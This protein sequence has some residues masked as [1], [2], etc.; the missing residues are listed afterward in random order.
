MSAPLTEDELAVLDALERAAT[1]VGSAWKKDVGCY[2]DPDGD[3]DMW[4]ARG[5]ML[6]GHRAT[7][8]PKAESDA[9]FIAALRN[10]APKLIAMA[11]DSLT[12]NHDHVVENEQHEAIYLRL[13]AERDHLAAE[14]ER[15][16]AEIAD[17]DAIHVYQL[18][19]RDRLAADVERLRAEIADADAIHVYQLA[20]RDRLAADVERLRAEL[21]QQRQG[22]LHNIK[23]ASKIQRELHDTINDERREATRLRAALEN[24]R[25][26]CLTICEANSIAVRALAGGKT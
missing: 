11:R 18:A 10:A 25:D 8:R 22:N 15:L 7:M 3:D 24:V 4:F 5:P 23:E 13:V 6:T 20:E 12:V 19:E 9:A 1:P 17:A 26:N 21:D 14:V 2:Q 16:R